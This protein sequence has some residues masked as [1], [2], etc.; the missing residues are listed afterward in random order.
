LILL[1]FVFSSCS[2]EIGPRGEAGPVGPKGE[3]G[4]PGSRGN[5]GKI[6]IIFIFACCFISNQ[7]KNIYCS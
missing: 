7:F 1:I 3:A 4:I 5:P 6:E 2:F